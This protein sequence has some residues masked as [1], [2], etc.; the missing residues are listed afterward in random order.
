M[1]KHFLFLWVLV[2]TSV[3]AQ[4]ETYSPASEY[5]IT[6]EFMLGISAEAND[7]FPER[8]LQKQVIVGFG[9]KHSHNPQEWAY[10][11]KAP[12]TGLNL[13]F[14]DLGNPD[15]LGYSVSLMPFI[16]FDAFG[17][18]QKDFKVFVGIGGSYFNVKYDEND[19]FFNQAIA[20]D[21][22]WSFRAS[23][24]YVLF[25][26]K[27]VDYRIGA[28]YFHSSNGHTRLPNQGLNSFLGSISADIKNPYKRPIYDSSNTFETP[29]KSVYEY[30][31]GR[32]GSGRNVLAL[33]FNDKKSVFTLAGE[34]GKVWNKTYKFGLGFY[35][36]YYDHYYDYIKGNETLVQDGKEFDSFKEKPFLNASALGV[37]A[38]FEFLLNH[39]GIDLQLGANLFKPAYKIDWRINEGWDNAPREIPDNWVYGEF[40][41][42]FKLKHIISS[43]MG[44]K[45][46]LFGTN[47]VPKNNFFVSAHINSNLGQADFSEVSIGYVRSFN[48]KHRN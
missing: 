23:F 7:F 26:T 14:T 37:Y 38:N 42:K 15:L 9:R 8:D 18:R 4:V 22:T 40:N 45:Y 17:R 28:V 47:E 21:L 10:W 3:I 41:T 27:S 6:P 16:E 43:R 20:T 25:K 29:K 12:K 34:Y 44:L 36:R 31:S 11:L 2:A 35:Y 32:F 30:W 48:L 5:V 39:V 46:Y 1:K 13:G 33:S 24:H 19:N